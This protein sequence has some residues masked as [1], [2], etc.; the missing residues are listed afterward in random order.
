MLP[1]KLKIFQNNQSLF[2]DYIDNPSFSD[3]DK[4]NLELVSLL[5]KVKITVYSV[6]EELYLQAIIINNSYK[7]Q[8]QLFYDDEKHYNSLYTLKFMENAT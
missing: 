3:F 8:I 4:I 6:S 2:R 1:T 7:K 5:F